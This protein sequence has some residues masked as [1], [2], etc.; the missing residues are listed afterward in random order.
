MGKNLLVKGMILGALAGGA[1]T[2]FD[3]D[4][5]KEVK[6]KVKK[7]NSRTTYY[8]RHP[9]DFVAEVRNQY[10]AASTMMTRQLNTAS[11]F[12]ADM[13]VLIEQ[14]TKADE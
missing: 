4:T 6:Y 13:E 11:K 10:Q 7:I 5:R 3:H 14:S 2:L 9:S 1:L 8:F 12:L